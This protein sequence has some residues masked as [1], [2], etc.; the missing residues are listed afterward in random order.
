MTTMRM[1]AQR[2]GAMRHRTRPVERREEV[3]D[4]MTPQQYYDMISRRHHHDGET[5]LLFAVLEDCLLY[6]S[7]CV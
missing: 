4:P 2:S 5:R 6:T 7:R 3:P 1:A